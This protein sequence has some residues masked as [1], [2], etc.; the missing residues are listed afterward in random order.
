MGSDADQLPVMQH[1]LARTWHL[2][3]ENQRQ[4]AIN[5]DDY[6][7]AGGIASALDQHADSLYESFITEAD[8]ARTRQIPVHSAVRCVWTGSGP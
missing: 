3:K 5:P 2:W 8:R 4:G 7:R 1:A 6:Q